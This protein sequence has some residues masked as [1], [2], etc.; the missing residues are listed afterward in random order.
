MVTADARHYY[1]QRDDADR[2]AVI[3]R[4]WTDSGCHQ[5][6]WYIPLY[7]ANGVFGLKVPDAHPY[8]KNGIGHAGVS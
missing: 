1:R 4:H 7:Y 6:L 2:R 8:E 5:S 3:T